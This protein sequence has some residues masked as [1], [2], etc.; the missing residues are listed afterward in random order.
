VQ[1]WLLLLL[2]LV[3]VVA[4][5]LLLLLM[6]VVVVVGVM[7]VVLASI[8]A[9]HPLDCAAPGRPHSPPAHSSCSR[10]KTHGVT[11]P[12]QL[13]NLLVGHLHWTRSSSSSSRPCPMR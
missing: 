3:V 7:L 12:Q 2:L 4:V 8:A 10:N 6:L 5:L 1:I 11:E 9:A 13:P